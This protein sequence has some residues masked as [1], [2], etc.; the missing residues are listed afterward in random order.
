MHV[1]ILQMFVQVIKELAGDTALPSSPYT[2]WRF[3]N[4]LQLLQDLKEAKFSNVACTSYSH[5][6]TFTLPDLVAFQLGPHGQS[7]PTLEKLKALGRD[8]IDKEAEKVSLQ[9]E[10][11]LP[12]GF[13]GFH[14]NFLVCMAEKQS[15]WEKL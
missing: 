4:P 6:M 5:P 2:P 1:D 14:E 8:N 3:S 11:G 7:R 10:C 15:M 13:R 9:N 12:W